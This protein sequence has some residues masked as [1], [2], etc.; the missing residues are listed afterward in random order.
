M[1]CSLTQLKSDCDDGGLVGDLYTSVHS[2][3][4][5]QSRVG[6]DIW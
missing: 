3:W 1:E 4:A 6:G 2:T 5:H